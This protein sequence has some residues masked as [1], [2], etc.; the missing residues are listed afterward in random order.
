MSK[1]KVGD[2]CYDDDYFHNLSLA[3]IKVERTSESQNE[4]PSLFANKPSYDP[5]PDECVIVGIVKP[6]HLRTPELI[7]IDVDDGEITSNSKSIHFTSTD[8]SQRSRKCKKRL[9]SIPIECKIDPNVIFID[10]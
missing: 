1:I 5:E 6:I 3:Q 10:D 7:D 9:P 8:S 2:L 4:S